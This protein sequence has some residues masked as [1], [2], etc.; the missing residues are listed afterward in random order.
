MMRTTAATRQNVGR[1]T[2]STNINT[3]MGAAVRSSMSLQ[4]PRLYFTPHVEGKDRYDVK[5]II[6]QGSYGVV[7]LA[8]DKADQEFVAIKRI[9]NVF[10]NVSDAHRTLRELKFLRVFKGHADLVAVKHIL[11]PSDFQ[12]FQDVYVVME[13]MD[14]DLHDIVYAHKRLMSEDECRVVLYQILRGMHAM[15][16]AGVIHRDVKPKNILINTAWNVKLCDFG[17]ARSME[18]G[19]GMN[20]VCLWTDY[21]ATRWYRPPEVCCKMYTHYTSAID[22]WA[23]GCIFA[24][25]LFGRPLFPGTS[26]MHQLQLITA[27]LGTPDPESVAKI[28]NPHAK[29]YFAALPA[30]ASRLFTLPQFSKLSAQAKSLMQ[31]LLALDHTRRLTAAEAMRHP[32]FVDHSLT[33]AGIAEDFAS[34]T[35]SASVASGR[36]SATCRSFTSSRSSAS[37]RSCESFLSRSKSLAADFH[38]ENWQGVLDQKN[39]RALVFEEILEYHPAFANMYRDFLHTPPAVVPPPDIRAATPVIAAAAPMNTPKQVLRDTSQTS[40]S[41]F[42][43]GLLRQERSE[44]EC[45][46][47]PD[48]TTSSSSSPPHHTVAAGHTAAAIMHDMSTIDLDCHEELTL[49]RDDPCDADDLDL[50]NDDLDLENDDFDTDAFFVH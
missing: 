37:A 21:I 8:W 5:E 31:G 35:S 43:S 2:S 41:T 29:T 16:A 24:E 45:V 44:E 3:G 48:F 28:D 32:F 38:F 40:S 46:R 42:A 33:S 11:Y 27:V 19:W 10:D 26:N 12:S 1:K 36:S 20:D 6:G 17:L 50:A 30:Q 13:I 7:C 25:L 39:I 4:D 34:S 15:H 9:T 49:A 14:H 47:V 22:V 23:V 18:P